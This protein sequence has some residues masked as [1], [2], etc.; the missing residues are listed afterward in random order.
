MVV[1]ELGANDG[2]RGHPIKSF[3]SNLTAIV[4]LAKNSGASVVLL[5]MEIPPNYGSRY[6][7]AFR[8]TY[9]EVASETG[10]TLSPFLLDG[11]AGN[12]ALTQADGIHP[13]QEAQERLL[14][15]ILPTL[16]GVLK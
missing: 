12:P 8:Q 11:V 1:V 10:S 2:L 6:T 4:R 13:R 14:K 9:S 7:Q 16:M 5:Q 15:N 3:Q